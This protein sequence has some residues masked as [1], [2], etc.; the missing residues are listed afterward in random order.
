MITGGLSGSV[1][2]SEAKRSRLEDGLG[3]AIIFTEQDTEGVQAP[4]N[5]AVV[6]TANIADYNVH[7]VFIDNESSINILY[8]SVF[9]QIKFTPDQLSRFDT[10]SGFLRRLDDSRGDD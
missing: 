3:D 2:L 6:V 1:E 8:Y 5:N 7:C 10:P 4:H 9:S